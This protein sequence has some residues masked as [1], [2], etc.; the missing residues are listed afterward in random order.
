M[1]T[2]FQ[3]NLSFKVIPYF[4]TKCK[5]NELRKTKQ[6]WNTLINTVFWPKHRSIQST[7]HGQVQCEWLE[8][9]VFLTEIEMIE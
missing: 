9:P 8:E 1:Y 5:K 6:N 3:A 2:E 7:A 4:K